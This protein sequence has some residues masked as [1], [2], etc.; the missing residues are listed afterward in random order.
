MTS[1]ST[2]LLPLD[3]L[4]W[5]A[6]LKTRQELLAR[7]LLLDEQLHIKHRRMAVKVDRLLQELL[8]NDTVALLVELG[9]LVFDDAKLTEIPSKLEELAKL[10]VSFKPWMLNCMAGCQSNGQLTGKEIDGLRRFAGVCNEAGVLSC[11]VTVLTTTTDEVALR[12]YGRTCLDQVLYYIEILTECGFTD[13][14]CSPLEASAVRARGFSIGLN[15]AGVRMPD[16]PPDDQ[17]RTLTPFEAREAGVTRQVIGRP[18][19]NG[20]V[21]ANAGKIEANYHGLTA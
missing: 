21:V 7:L 3:W 16:S 15:C 2:E 19:T 5:S 11:G 14:V 6:D 18:I 20:D 1:L 9:Y 10:H 12:Q 4:I 17:A 8:G 13:A